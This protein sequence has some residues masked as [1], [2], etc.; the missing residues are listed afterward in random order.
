MCNIYKLTHKVR[1]DHKY[2]TLGEKKKWVGV[3][4]NASMPLA[5]MKINPTLCK[6]PVLIP[7][8]RKGIEMSY[9]NV[10]E[11]FLQK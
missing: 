10:E 5:P 1:K 2:K 3:L 9:E 6:R 11:N 7:A 8:I 4:A